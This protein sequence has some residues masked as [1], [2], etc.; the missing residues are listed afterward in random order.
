MSQTEH[1]FT[2]NLYWAMTK[3]QP[4]NGKI[5]LI[6]WA[7]KDVKIQIGVDIRIVLFWLAVPA[8]KEDAV[9]NFL[10]KR[11]CKTNTFHFKNMLLLISFFLEALGAPIPFCVSLW[12]HFFLIQT[13]SVWQCKT[14]KEIWGISRYASSPSCSGSADCHQD[15]VH[16]FYTVLAAEIESYD[17]NGQ[18][19]ITIYRQNLSQWAM[20]THPVFRV[21]LKVLSWRT[22]LGQTH[23][24]RY[25]M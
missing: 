17:N 24:D 23:C 5:I 16:W 9:G 7:W 1:L 21:R 10:F 8:D 25:K 19:Q 15:E 4:N 20:V 11:T 14:N 6:F 3:I 13:W 2:I 12:D 22:E 18:N